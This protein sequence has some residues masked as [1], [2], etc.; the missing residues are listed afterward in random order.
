MHIFVTGASGFVGS[1]VVAELIGAGH[2]VLGFARS[3]AAADKLAA[4]GADVHRG[5]LEDIESLKRGAAGSD[6]VIHCAFI[7][8]FSKFAENSAIDKRAIDA[9]GETLA[10]SGKPL[11]A[12]SGVALLQPGRVSTEETVRPP[13][14][15]A[16][17]RVS[18]EASLAFAPRGVRAM[19]I[20]LPPTVHGEGD[21]GFVPTL[22][23]IAREKGAAAYVGEGLNRWPA[24]HRFDAARAY[25][26]A[27]EKGV[28]GARYHAIAEE[29]VPFRD[30]AAVIGKRLGVPVISVPPEKAADHFGWFAMFAAVDTPASSARTREALGWTP[31]QL[32]LIEDLDQPCYFGG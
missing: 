12:T 26:L 17:P 29:G 13:G 31:G 28:S 11:I 20:R 32:G 27:V 30:I 6:G 5:S 7:H 18:E 1:A 9:L 24:V 19:A 21:H 2:S 25:R 14:A 15:F 4:A 23:R 16:V 3:D 8:D 10:G 22:I